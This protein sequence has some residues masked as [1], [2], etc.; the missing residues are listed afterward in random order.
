MGAGLIPACYA[1]VVAGCWSPVPPISPA[2]PPLLPAN[3]SDASGACC[4]GRM[5]SAR[6]GR[7]RPVMANVS[8]KCIALCYFA[9]FKRV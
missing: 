4:V 7:Q 3:V 6:V 1:T 5:P 9:W 8:S 2:C